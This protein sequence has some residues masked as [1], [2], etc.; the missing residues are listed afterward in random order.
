MWGI[1][2]MNAKM[3]L[4]VY[5]S[6]AGVIISLFTAVMTYWIIDV[7]IGS[8][9]MFKIFLTV[10]ATLPIIGILSYL[11]GRCLS[12]RLA[13][14]SHCL[15]DI[16]EDKFL[17]DKHEESITD[18][19]AI[20][21]SIHE[22]SHR[23]EASISTLK[24]NNAQLNNMILSLSHDIKTPLTI[25]EGYLEELEDG[26]VT[27]D[28]KPEALATLKKETAYINELSSEVIHYLQSLENKTKKESIV[29]KDF[30]HKEV[31]PLIRAPKEVELKCEIK[32]GFQIEFDRIGLKSILVNLLH[33]ATKHTTK[34]S[35]TVKSFEN[36][37]IIED[38]GVGIDSKD[39]EMIFE[40]FYCVDE[41]KN[42]EKSGF[43]L[44]LSIAKNLAENNGYALRLDS[45]YG[46]GCRFVLI[47]L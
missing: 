38:T 17:T 25:I 41:S 34:G 37:V 14:I 12:E 47:T 42:R 7:P 27:E 36:G 13:A 46:D 19:N 45:S 6:I 22:L 10:L 26:I 24:K 40:P 23:L 4:I 44:G 28:Q 1:H 32:E 11:I 20:H 33:N 16:S 21:E 5:Y 3:Y 29:L 35:I 2:S 18:I 9:M 43:G 15:N 30:L 39:A 8:K 31:C